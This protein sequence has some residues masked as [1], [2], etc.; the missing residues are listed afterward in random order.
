MDFDISVYGIIADNKTIPVATL[1]WMAADSTTKINEYNGGN[2]AI[3]YW[4][5]TNTTDNR[6]YD[7]GHGETDHTEATQVV[8]TLTITSIKDNTTSFTKNHTGI[9]SPATRHTLYGNS[10]MFQGGNTWFITFSTGSL[11]GT[12]G[13]DVT[14]ILSNHNRAWV[15]N[16]LKDGCIVGINPDG[17]FYFN[18]FLIGSSGL[19]NRLAGYVLPF[20]KVVTN[21]PQTIGVTMVPNTR[22]IRFMGKRNDNVNEPVELSYSTATPEINA[23]YAHEKNYVSLAGQYY[24]N[25]DGSTITQGAARDMAFVTFYDVRYFNRSLSNE[26]MTQ[27][28]DRMVNSFQD[29]SKTYSQICKP[30]YTW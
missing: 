11:I 2:G 17:T 14:Y 7:G 6:W 4:R 1:R 15:T 3:A 30:T 16:G 20:K 12:M 27:V 24:L 26:E 18:S 21:V 28:Y 9:M 19:T 25:S 13:S 23:P 29:P 5:A 10:G 8:R 22:T